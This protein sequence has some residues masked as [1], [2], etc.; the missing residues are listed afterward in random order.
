MK[1]V[2]LIFAL[3]ISMATTTA[4]AGVPIT[5]VD[6]VAPTDEMFMDMAVTAAKK[7][8][9]EGK[10]ACGAVVILNGA[11]RSTGIPA[12]GK[13]AEHVAFEKARR[14]TLRNA[15]IYTVNEPTTETYNLLCQAGAEAIFFV[16]PREAVVAAGI[17]PADAYDDSKIDS[18]LTPVPMT[19]LPYADAQALIKK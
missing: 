14:Q 8:R 18:E 1:K 3:I 10:K 11:W 2:L 19:C 4:F 12:D 15:T 5:K 17:Y 6:K 7:A 16:N 9:A 13:T